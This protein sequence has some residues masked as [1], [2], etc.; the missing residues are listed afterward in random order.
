M[1]AKDKTELQQL[2]HAIELVEANRGIMRAKEKVKLPL[3][4]REE[5][6]VQSV[7]HDLTCQ[8]AL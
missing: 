2:E 3:H 6:L 1:L 4:S 7:R 8:E 5:H